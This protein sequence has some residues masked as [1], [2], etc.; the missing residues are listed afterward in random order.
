M[1][2]KIFLTTLNG[3]NITGII[4]TVSITKGKSEILFENDLGDIY[5][6]HPATI[7][8]FTFEEGGEVLLY[9][10]KYL[11]GKWRFLR[12]DQKGTALT[13][14]TSLERQ[15]QFTNS[16]E[17]PIIIEEK[18]PQIWLQFQEEQPIKVYR[19]TYRRVLRKKL[20][21]FP[22]LAKRIGKRGFKYKNM[23]SI[24]DL[25]NRL[26]SEKG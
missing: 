4:K 3:S 19:L 26:H 16:E 12:A 6:I 21:A 2:I 11:G 10:S 17:S 22:E 7:F 1:P 20:E 23:S 8:G 25:Y 18:N 15:L 13:M 5:T 14:Y 24:V 9:E